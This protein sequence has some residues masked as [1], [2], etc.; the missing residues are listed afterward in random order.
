MQTPILADGAG[1]ATARSFTTSASE[2]PH[3][4]IDLRIAPELWLKRLVVGGFDRVFE[5][6]PSFRNEG[7][8][9]TLM[10]MEQA[11]KWM[12]L[13]LDSTHNPEFTTCEFYRAFVDL[14]FLISTT[15]SIFAGLGNHIRDR[16]DKELT[17][18]TFPSIDL[19]SPFRQIDFIPAVEAAMGVQ[20]PN[21]TH[22][23]AEEGIRGLLEQRSIPILSSTTLPHMLDRLS[24][25]YLEPQ[26]TEPTFILNHPECL[27][28]LSKSF[29]HPSNSQM[30]SARAELFVGCT[31]I[32]NMY[33][34]ENSPME[35]RRKFEE[36][37]QHRSHET[38]AFVDESYL[39][40]LE[41][42]LPPT[43]GWGCGIERLCMLFSGASRIGDVLPFGSLRN[44]VSL[45]AVPP[46]DGD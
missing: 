4:R 15:Q 39:D 44:V 42:G 28:P 13:G 45:R 21:L 46:G 33:E 29:R 7:D 38:Q 26:C 5:I 17:E 34:E 41:W 6:G 27:S 35:Q 18:L 20:L 23:D 9:L 22:P 36:Q 10:T 11:N 40:A 31:E 2:F 16:I 14:D 19:T 43:G 8:S 30:V 25:K 37:L 32:A 1:G 24:S 3:R 12:R